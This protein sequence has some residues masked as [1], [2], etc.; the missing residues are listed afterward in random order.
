MGRHNFGDMLMPWIV[1]TM[2]QRRYGFCP[3]DFLHADVAGADMRAYGG[4]LVI[5]VGSL[6]SNMYNG[7]LDVILRG[8]GTLNNLSLK[9][10]LSMF[11][12]GFKACNEDDFMHK[13]L[14]TSYLLPK[15]KFAKPGL[16]IANTVGGTGHPIFNQSEFDHCTLRQHPLKAGYEDCL[17]APDSVVMINTVFGKPI[18][19]RT[20]GLPMGIY[21]ALQFRSKAKFD[22]GVVDAVLAAA[23]KNNASI[24][25]FRAGAA[26]FHDNLMSYEALKSRFNKADSSI[27]VTVFEGLNIWDISA[28][29]SRAKLLISTSLH[30][31]IVA[32]SFY[33]PRVTLVW[34]P[35]GTIGNSKLFEFM[36]LWDGDW[37]HSHDA[38]DARIGLSIQEALRPSSKIVFDSS[39]RRSVSLYENVFK[40]WADSLH[41]RWKRDYV[42]ETR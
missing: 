38:T 34:G 29:I 1:E 4:H 5:G 30:C 24:V 27:A 26:R 8:G 18:S 37:N 32:F 39:T 25:M 19:F 23:R 3:D 20:N 33:V 31:R 16:F 13:G 42:G 7:S 35:G 14:S 41:K 2:L 22:D 17:L 9:G 6:F 15:Y 40:T 11:G 36:K 10:A 28:L 21:F 12:P